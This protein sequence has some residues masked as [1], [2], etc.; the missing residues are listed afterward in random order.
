MY[1]QNAAQYMDDGNEED[2]NTVD[3]AKLAIWNYKNKFKIC[4]SPMQHSTSP[5][6]P[7]SV[8]FQTVFVLS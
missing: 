7:V 3:R 1:R 5:S 4:P 2:N 8:A 6:P